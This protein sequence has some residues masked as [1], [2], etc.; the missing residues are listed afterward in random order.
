MALHL[1]VLSPE[2]D[3]GRLRPLLGLGALVGVPQRILRDLDPVA[4][5]TW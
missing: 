2:G 1:A 4:R 5:S 3:A